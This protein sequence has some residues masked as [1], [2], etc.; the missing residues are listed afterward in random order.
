MDVLLGGGFDKDYGEVY[1]VIDSHCVTF[2]TFFFVVCA[3]R[4]R[5]N[6]SLELSDLR[7]IRQ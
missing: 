2:S 6:P 7:G 4:Q 3:G 1:A 5:P